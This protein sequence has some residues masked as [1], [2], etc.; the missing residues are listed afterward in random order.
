MEISIALLQYYFLFFHI[1]ITLLLLLKLQDIASHEI[2]TNAQ[3]QVHDL[4][5][6]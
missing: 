2:K 6:I 1:N 4:S 3:I 5:Q